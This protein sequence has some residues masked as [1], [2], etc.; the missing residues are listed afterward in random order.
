MKTRVNFPKW[1]LTR[2]KY[3]LKTAYLVWLQLLGAIICFL[4]L[5]R[6]NAFP[7]LSG[8]MTVGQW[9]VSLMSFL[10][11]GEIIVVNSKSTRMDTVWSMSQVFYISISLS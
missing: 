2:A 5:G 6:F 4:L 1:Q 3:C 9:E 8:S 7:Q 10:F 11:K